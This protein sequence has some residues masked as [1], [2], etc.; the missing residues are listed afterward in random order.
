MK[1]IF[2]ALF[3]FKEMPPFQKKLCF[4]QPLFWVLEPE[5][6]PVKAGIDKFG[7]CWA[8]LS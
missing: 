6:Q 7:A 2:F 5:P 4:G 3:S 1:P 8:G